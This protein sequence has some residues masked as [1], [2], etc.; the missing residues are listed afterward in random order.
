MPVDTP[1]EISSPCIVL[2]QRIHVNAGSLPGT[3]S[4]FLLF[5]V[6]GT[7]LE[8]MMCAR[9]LDERLRVSIHVLCRSPFLRT[10]CSMNLVRRLDNHIKLG[11]T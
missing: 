6:H 2:L 9:K 5:L 7:M 11:C 4:V 10:F 8:Q 3:I 1:S